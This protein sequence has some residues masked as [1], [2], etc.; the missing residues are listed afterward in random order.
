MNTKTDHFTIGNIPVKVVRKDIK[1]M[2]LAV[3]PPAGKIRL[4]APQKMDT[5]VIR[6]FAISKLPWIKRQIK[7]FKEQSRETEKEY[8]SGESHY[9]K[10]RRMIL[11]VSHTKGHTDIHIKGYKTIQLQVKPGTPSEKK[12][13]LLKE[14]YRKEL[15]A[16]IPALIAKWENILGVQVNYWGVKHMRTK[17]G[18]CNPDKKGIWINL[19]LAK[20][21]L[22]CLEYI[23][24]HE[25]IHLKER[26]HNKN[27]IQLLNQHLPGWKT[28]R[29]ELNELPVHFP[30]IK[31]IYTHP[32]QY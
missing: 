15:K 29:K 3:Y 1:H 18:T 28:V 2:H 17:W 11:S 26:H 7:S 4:S 5:E 20:K 27:F 24:I 30:A 10:G 32:E 8:I 6:M 12:A 25:L 21:P 19:E 16:V 31:D 9:Y 22:K 14:W 23:I 13:I